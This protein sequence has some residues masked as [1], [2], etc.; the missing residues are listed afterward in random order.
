M[1]KTK[2]KIVAAV[3]VLV[4]AVGGASL[5]VANQPSAKA[6]TKP[7]SAQQATT[8]AAKLTTSA[9]KQTVSYEGQTGKTALAVL[10]SLAAVTT[11]QSSYGEFVTGINGVT[12]DG[13]TQYWSFYV[14]GKLANEGAGTYKTTNGQK[15][16]W[17]V[18]SVQ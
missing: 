15:I 1:E 8:P 13:T 11:Q 7:N 6:S 3:A 14:N 18:E 4:V 16:E 9:D 17:R 5:Y 2:L 10:T 12:A